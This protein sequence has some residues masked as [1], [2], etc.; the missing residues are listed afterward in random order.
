VIERLSL[1]WKRFSPLEERL[2]E[3]VRR[4]L[5]E[6]ARGAFAA[7]VA[8]INRVQRSPPSW[9]EICF[10]RMRWGK[11][12]WV[13]VASFPCTDEFRL[14]EVRFK[15]GGR[16]FKST[17][18]CV[19]GYILDFATSPGPR[20]VAFAAWEGEAKAVLIGDPLRAPSGRR[21]PEVLPRVWD[22]V[23]ERRGRG[24]WGEWEV[25]D[26]STAYRLALDDGEYLVLAEREGDQLILWRIEPPSEG[27]FHLPNH[28]GVPEALAEPEEFIERGD[29]R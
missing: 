6:A 25:H 16:R 22:A 21:E 11:A 5:P 10:Y 19:R 18:T 4:I 20:S 14:A 1:L 8:G 27:L 26:S 2:I 15:A 29:R 12:S 17:L 24:P 28:D 3:E 9:G 23:L 7:Q 13:G